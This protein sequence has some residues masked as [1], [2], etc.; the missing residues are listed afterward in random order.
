MLD[1]VIIKLELTIERS[2]MFSH[3]EKVRGYR[4]RNSPVQTIVSESFQSNICG[5]CH[6]GK[7]NRLLVEYLEWICFM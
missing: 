4:K 7:K 2:G 1:R 5:E 6:A 3:Q